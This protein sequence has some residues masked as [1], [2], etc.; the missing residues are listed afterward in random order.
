MRPRILC[1]WVTTLQRLIDSIFDQSKDFTA[2]IKILIIFPTLPIISKNKD[3]LVNFTT[4]ENKGK[5]L[6]TQKIWVCLS[7]KVIISFEC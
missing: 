4:L 7:N 5:I 2:W 1:N 6:T 3:K